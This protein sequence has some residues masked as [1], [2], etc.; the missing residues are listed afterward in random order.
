[1]TVWEHKVI[2]GAEG[3]LYPYIYG[4]IIPTNV[5]REPYVQ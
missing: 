4:N 2:G 3:I 5:E 1:M